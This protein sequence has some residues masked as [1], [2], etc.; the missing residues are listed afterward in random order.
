MSLFVLN[1]PPWPGLKL[2]SSALSWRLGGP[3][4]Q[5]H[6]WEETQNRESSFNTCRPGG[7][8]CRERWSLLNGVASS[9][10]Q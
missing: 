5:S 7:E 9:P 4:M 1:T 6:S 8:L 3:D 10:E 2:L